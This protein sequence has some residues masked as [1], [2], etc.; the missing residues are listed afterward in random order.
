LPEQHVIGQRKRTYLKSTSVSS[1]AVPPAV[2]VNT[3]PYLASTTE[4]YRGPKVSAPA[5]PD[6]IRC[7]V[8]TCPVIALSGGA[9]WNVSVLESETVIELPL[10]KRPCRA[11]DEDQHHQTYIG[12]M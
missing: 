3:I 1:S 7:A 10:P 12:K 4:A 6:R 9:F 11:E 8:W 5:E 2:I